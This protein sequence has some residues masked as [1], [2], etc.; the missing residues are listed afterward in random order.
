M[1]WLPAIVLFLISCT[2]G[3]PV[4]PAS[5]AFVFPQGVDPQGAQANDL[6]QAFKD[7][8]VIARMAAVTMNPYCDPVFERYFFPEEL[9]F[10]SNVFRTIANIPLDI[11]IEDLNGGLD[12]GIQAMVTGRGL[13]PTFSLLSI[14][15]GNHPD[16]SPNSGDDCAVEGTDAYLV[17]SKDNPDAGLISMC[18]P[19]WDYP[20]LQ[21]ILNPPAGWENDLGFGCDNL[22][23]HDSDLM[24]P[25]GGVLLHELLHWGFLF[26]NEVPNFETVIPLTSGGDHHIRDYEGPPGGIPPDGYGPYSAPLLKNLPRGTYSVTTNNVDNYLY[27]ALSKYWYI[28]C[29][30]YFA[31]STSSSDRFLRNT[32]WNRYRQPAPSQPPSQSQTQSQPPPKRSIIRDH[33]GGYRGNS[34]THAHIK[35]RT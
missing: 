29:T 16:R 35:T 11:S 9:Q 21:N 3:D 10:V 22:L 1:S 12:P 4:D 6:R 8:I 17:H 24:T 31:Q 27:F 14:S 19:V 2:F 30:K 26:E 5:P 13:N 15:I 28:Q 20:S 18:T 32:A 7:A 34:T 33:V 25:A 23:D